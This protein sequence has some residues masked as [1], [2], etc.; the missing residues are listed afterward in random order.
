MYLA[1]R[2]RRMHLLANNVGGDDYGLLSSARLQTDLRPQKANGSPTPTFTR[3]TTKYVLGYAAGAVI[4]DGPTLIACASGEAA[5]WGARRVSE[6]VWSVVDANGVALTTTNGA[7]ALCCD[8][9]GP[10]GY[11]AEGARTNLCLRS[12]TLGTTWTASDVTIGSNTDVAPD[13]T[14]TM[15]RIVE[16]ATTAAHYIRQS[17]TFTA[18]AWTCSVYVRP[19]SAGRYVGFFCGAAGSG[20]GGANACVVFNPTT[21]AVSATGSDWTSAGVEALPDGSYRCYATATMNAGAALFDVRLANAG[22]T[23]A[24]NTGY[25]GDGTSYVPVWGVQVEAGAFASSY[26]PTTTAATRNIDVDQYVSAGNLN[27]AAMTVA[28]QWTP[29]AASM[30]T[31][32]LFGTYVDANNYTAILHD[33]TNIVARKRI[34]G[35]NADAT[36]ALTYA[37]NTVYRIT[38]RFD[39]TNGVDVWVDGTKGTGAATTTASQIGTNFQIGADGNGANSG[40]GGHRL[41]RVYG[42]SLSDSQAAAL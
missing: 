35:V 41:F 1:K 14:T 40:F 6:G 26:T 34:G 33:G 23:S 7:S 4:A 30:G 16:A 15:D 10:Y 8:A 21:G 28:L 5:F 12:Q 11:F 19:G 13:G 9:R 20:G 24:L 36:K 32:F 29:E 42:R 22:T 38:A 17:I 3:A 2:L 39:S 37:A 27:A 31:V 25:A 18:A